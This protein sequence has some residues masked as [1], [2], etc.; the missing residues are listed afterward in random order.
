MR[1]ISII[2]L[3]FAIA[4]CS[5]PKLYQQGINKI[6]KAIEKDPSIK[7][8][9]DTLDPIIKIETH[10]DTVDNEIIKTITKTERI[11]IDTC[12]FDCDKVKTGRQLRHERKN[13]QRLP[14]EHGE[15]VQARDKTKIRFTQLSQAAESTTH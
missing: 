7:L 8:P 12:E 13:V 4:S 14:E 1:L 11:Y 6:N 10:I 2:I 3:V 15:N 9:A 5:A